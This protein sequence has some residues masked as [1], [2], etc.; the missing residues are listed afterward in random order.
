MT[1]VP[2]PEPSTGLQ[3]IAT[4]VAGLAKAAMH[5]DRTPEVELRRRRGVCAACPQATAG[6]ARTSRCQL[7][8][9][10]IHPKTAV[11]TER[12]PRGLW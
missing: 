11:A 1:N 10:F 9:C 2:N 4:G 7:C 12:C 3:R 5:V 8:T 6:S